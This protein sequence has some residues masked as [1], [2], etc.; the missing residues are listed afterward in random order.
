[1]S[2]KEIFYN[3]GYIN[4]LDK[5]KYLIKCPLHNEVNGNSFFINFNNNKYSCFGKCQTSG[6]LFELINILKLEYSSSEINLQK[7]IQEEDK[8]E[9]V[10]I[11]FWKIKARFKYGNETD[12][13][14]KRK[15]SREQINNNFIYYN[16]EYER[17]YF[18]LFM[19]GKCYGYTKRTVINPENIVN[20]INSKY[21]ID[22]KIIDLEMILN[23]NCL[24]KNN[25]LTNEIKQDILN[26]YLNDFKKYN[27]FIK[28]TNDKNINK[29]IL[30]YENLTNNYDKKKKLVILEGIFDT[31]YINQV[32]ECNTIAFLGTGINQYKI[33]YINDLVKKYNLEL[34][35]SFDNDPTGKKFTKQ[36]INLSNRFIKRV[37]YDL[38]KKDFKDYESLTNND[39]Q[40]LFNNLIY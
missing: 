39:I 1:M 2:Y 24:Y 22:L 23:E 11:P 33:N 8:K 26:N 28:Y 4:N 34:I 15:I 9:L 30:L 29:N 14:E 20:E 13:F 37:N 35:L 17:V 5:N 10:E 7:T 18:P 6:S 36:F 12:Y 19:G 31:L 16:K 40:L 25:S 32:L 21:N 3:N 27:Y 38:I